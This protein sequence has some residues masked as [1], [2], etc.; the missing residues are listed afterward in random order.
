M[1][2]KYVLISFVICLYRVFHT[3][4]DII[5]RYLL[6]LKVKKNVSVNIGPEV[7][8]FQVIASKNVVLFSVWTEKYGYTKFLGTQISM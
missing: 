7:L 2:D 4:K 5:S 3:N 8:C 1:Q 6:M